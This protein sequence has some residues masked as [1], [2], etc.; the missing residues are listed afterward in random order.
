MHNVYR[1]LSASLL[2]LSLTISAGDSVADSFASPVGLWQTIDDNTHK[3]T[4]IIEITQTADG[5]LN[6][7]AVKGLLP[8]DDGRRCS[9]CSDE[10]KDQ[11]I[12]GMTLIK[13]MKQNGEQNSGSQQWRRVQM[14]DASDRWW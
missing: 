1:S 3:P 9:A 11:L 2:A 12:Q 4:A 10:R 6:G 5:M 14:Q 13:E 8:G 7:K